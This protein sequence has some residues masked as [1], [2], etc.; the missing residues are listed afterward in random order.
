LRDAKET[1]LAH[2]EAKGVLLPSLAFFFNIYYLEEKAKDIKKCTKK[3]EHYCTY[4]IYVPMYF[5]S[6]YTL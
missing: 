6:F 2:L 3:V 5:A 1:M 4:G